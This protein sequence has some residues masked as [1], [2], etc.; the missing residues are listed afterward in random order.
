MKV[1]WGIQHSQWDPDEGCH[2]FEHVYFRDG[3]KEG[4]YSIWPVAGS[5]NLF[6]DRNKLSQMVV[7]IHN[8][9]IEETLSNTSLY[10]NRKARNPAAPLG[11]SFLV[12]SRPFWKMEPYVDI[13]LEM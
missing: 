9:A 8:M 13:M 4:K 12:V 1:F 2:C 3:K 10:L 5:P 11:V 7:V 6:N